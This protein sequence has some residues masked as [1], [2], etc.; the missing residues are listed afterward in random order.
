MQNL[1]VDSIAQTVQQIQLAQSFGADASTSLQ[2]LQQE[3]QAAQMQGVA[4]PPELQQAV[5]QIL[6]QAGLLPGMGQDGLT[7]GAGEGAGSG[8]PGGT[9]SSSGGGGSPQAAADGGGQAA[10]TQ[11]DAPGAGPEQTWKLAG[12]FDQAMANEPADF[13]NPEAW[14]QGDTAGNCSSVAVIKA[15]TAESGNAIFQSV[16]K[17]EEGYLV[18]TQDGRTVKL[19]QAE[20]A[21]AEKTADFEGPDSASKAQAVMAAGVMAKNYQAEH[22][23][24][25]YQQ[26]LNATNGVVDPVSN[27]KGEGRFPEQAAHDLGIPFTRTSV[28]TAVNDVRAGRG[29]EAAIIYND[30]HAEV[31]TGNR[32]GG[33]RVD[34]YGRSTNSNGQISKN[35][36][37]SQATTGIELHSKPKPAPKAA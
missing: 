9:G 5:E 2:Q 12:L 19:S 8:A 16:Q 6:S 30:R 20:L 17:T 35:G 34:D 33:A 10:A 32:Q 1:L 18:T 25:T 31:V 28:Q 3:Y 21:A 14:A 7:P 15:A 37:T 29:S 27:P 26:A 11:N 36:Q 4:L 24:L 13:R 23:N 22:P